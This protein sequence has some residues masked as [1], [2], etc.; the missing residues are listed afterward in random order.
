[1]NRKIVIASI[2]LL[3]MAGALIGFR[4]APEKKAMPNDWSD[5][6][7][8]SLQAMDYMLLHYGSPDV[9][10]E[11]MA[12]WYSCSPWKWTIVYSEAVSHNFPE[13][14]KDVIEQCMAFRVPWYRMN[15]I[16]EFNG[17]V[18]CSRTRGEIKVRCAQE[19]LNFLTIN[20]VY[21]IVTRKKDVKSA[22]NYLAAA[23]AK[24]MR[25]ERKDPYTKK[26]LAIKQPGKLAD[27]D[28]ILQRPVISVTL[29]GLA[30]E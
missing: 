6:S 26:F 14:H 7:D 19:A 17:S 11:K 18:E 9:Q 4:N 16:A 12:I 24:Y 3:G 2:L 27:P 20:M 29:P 25:G 1:M 22:R 8:E 13:P 21:E 15:D 10:T 28:T 30:K 23:S 5:W